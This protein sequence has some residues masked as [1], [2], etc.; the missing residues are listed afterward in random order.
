MG[1][2]AP[3]AFRRDGLDWYPSGGRGH[4]QNLQPDDE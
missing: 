4:Y 3:A 1:M 2:V